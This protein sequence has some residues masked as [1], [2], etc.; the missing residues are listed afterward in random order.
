M[1]VCLYE[2]FIVFEAKQVG[3]GKGEEEKCYKPK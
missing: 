2:M 3:G 1:E